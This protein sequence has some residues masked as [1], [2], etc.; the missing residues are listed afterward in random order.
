M[1]LPKIPGTS[2][3][4]DCNL[5]MSYSSPTGPFLS[6]LIVGT[7]KID[8]LTQSNGVKNESVYRYGC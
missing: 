3:N 5:V 7:L 4:A 8:S 2:N 6:L 1:Y